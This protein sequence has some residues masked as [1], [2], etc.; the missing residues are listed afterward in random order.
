MARRCALIRRL[1]AVE[2]LRCTTVI[3]ADNTGTLTENP[4]EPK[5]LCI[6]AGSVNP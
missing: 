3:C 2:T 4:M 6:A 5:Q 1:P